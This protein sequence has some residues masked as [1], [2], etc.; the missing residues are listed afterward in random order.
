MAAD[1]QAAT[2]TAGNVLGLTA[3]PKYTQVVKRKREA[4][5]DSNNPKCQRRCGACKAD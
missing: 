1:I 3:G 4:R 5:S 2:E